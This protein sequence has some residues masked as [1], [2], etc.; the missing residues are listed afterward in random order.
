MIEIIQV[1]LNDR[2]QV[3][4]FIGLPFRLYAQTPQWVPPFISDVKVMM[5][6]KKHPFYEHS[7]AVFF[8]AI[9]NGKPVG[10]I[11]VLENKPFNK[12]HGTKQS[13]FGLFECVNDQEIANKL[14][15][16]AFDWSRARG[17]DKIVGPKG[18]SSFDGYGLQ[19]EGF[20]HRQM[21]TMSSYNF[22]YYQALVENLGFEKEV[23]FVSCYTPA[24]QFHLPDK[25]REVARRVRERGILK[26][27]NFQTKREI[28][29]WAGRIGEAYNKTF[30]HNWEYYPLSERE[31]KFVLDSLITAAVPKLYK[32]ITYNDQII[33]FLLGF[34]DISRA[35]QRQKG[36]ITPWGV[37]DIL[38]ELQKTKMI[39][40][41]GA[42]VLPEF[43]G[44]GGNA[45]LYSEMESTIRNSRF[46]EAEMTQVAET[47]PQMRRDLITLGGIPYKNHRVYHLSI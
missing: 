42:G 12:Y 27:R 6:P 22:A 24:D 28:V 37:A 32:F 31:I 45:L 29:E 38:I 5:D 10:R 3:N 1:D 36:R 15:R 14:F 23:D 2:R 4:E 43:H 26:V 25:V 17:L 18:L 34:P 7:E 16:R 41:N 19:I 20:E 33:G 35:L 9:Q 46:N 44:L 13:V 47:T 30:V 11:A 21:M 39:S 40:I 8:M